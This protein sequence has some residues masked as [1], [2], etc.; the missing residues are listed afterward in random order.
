MAETHINPL[1]NLIGYRLRRASADAMSDLARAL[2]KIGLRPTEASALLLISVNE[3]MTQSDI[4]RILGI[5]R[6]NM[7]PLTA[8]LERQG[9]I[10]RRRMDGRSQSLVVSEHGAEIAARIHTAMK[11]HDQQL[12]AQVPAGARDG[13]ATALGTLAPP[14]GA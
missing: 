6:A 9:M 7:A 11:R 4:G 10:T 1:E 12:V 3:G 5:Q 13:F 2:G 8:G 14:P